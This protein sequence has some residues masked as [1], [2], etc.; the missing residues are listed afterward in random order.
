[1]SNFS[2]T[3]F[4]KEPFA[5]CIIIEHVKD[6]EKCGASSL[7]SHSPWTSIY[8]VYLS[9]DSKFSGYFQWLLSVNFLQSYSDRYNNL[10]YSRQGMC[11]TD[12]NLQLSHSFL[13]SCGIIIEVGLPWK[14][15][16]SPFK[17]EKTYHWYADLQSQFTLCIA[18]YSLCTFY[19][20]RHKVFDV[21][22]KTVIVYNRCWYYLKY[23]KK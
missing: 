8:E 22:Q 4:W 6:N 14:N 1:M 13:I 16:F 18:S 7:T 23:E 20:Q 9:S 17:E 2:S 10:G 12:S 19:H 5:E 15:K 3:N 11:P 21:L